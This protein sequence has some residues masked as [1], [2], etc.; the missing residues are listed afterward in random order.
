MHAQYVPVLT[1]I[2]PLLLIRELPQDEYPTP[3]LPRPFTSHDVEPVMFG[4]NI[5]GEGD[6][7]FGGYASTGTFT[8]SMYHVSLQ[9]LPGATGGNDYYNGKPGIGID[10]SRSSSIYKASSTVQPASVR[11]LACIKI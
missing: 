8:G 11:L 4:P 3:A 5:S 2:A 7:V 1:D 6:W 9:N 10:A